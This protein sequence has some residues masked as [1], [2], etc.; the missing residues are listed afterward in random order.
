MDYKK[1]LQKII[2]KERKNAL[3]IGV[4]FPYNETNGVFATVPSNAWTNGYYPGLMWL[5]YLASGEEIFK[6]NAIKLEEKLDE[7]INSFTMPGHD[8]GFVWLLSSGI[9]NTIEKNQDSRRRLLNM[10][11][12]LAGRFNIKGNYI[13]AWDCEDGNVEIPMR[14]IIDCMMNIPLLFMASDITGDP[15]YSHIAKA[16]ADTTIKYFI[17]FDGAVRHVCRFNPHTGEF[18]EAIGGQGYSPVSSWSR[19]ASWAIYGFAMAYRYT[20]DKKYLETAIKV[21]KFFVSNIQGDFVPAWDFRAPN[22]EIKDTS[23]GAI[24]ASGLIEIYSHT[25]DEY[26][27]NQAEKIIASL[28]ENCMSP[29]D[30]QSI[31]QRATAFLGAN[32]NVEAGLIYADYYFTEAVYKLASGNLNPPWEYEK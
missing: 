23:A 9:H 6:D 7:V 22:K 5:S 31:L 13:R 20:S 3:Q 21:A 17:D 12:Y 25:K 11:S 2:E 19:G 32:E 18:I 10:A 1:L 29:E 16:H 24:A 28:S 30:S 15:R 27:K 14:A 8:V 4:A 26:Y